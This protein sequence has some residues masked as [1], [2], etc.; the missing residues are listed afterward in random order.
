MLCEAVLRTS[1][2]ILELGTGD[3]STLA[4]HQVSKA[5]QRTVLSFDNDPNWIARFA[6]L[7]S[8]NHLLASLPSWNDCPI[9]SAIWSV[10]FVDHAPAERRAIEIRRLTYRAQV[11]VVHD[12]ED[13]QYGYEAVFGAFAYRRDDRAYKQWTT[14]LSNY[15]DVSDWNIQHDRN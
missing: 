15:I 10:A 5:C 8:D 9:E 6:A 11:I 2:P 12:T 14:V 4:L 7:R 13:P 1:G 3:G